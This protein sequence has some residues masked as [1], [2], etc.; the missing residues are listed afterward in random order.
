MLKNAVKKF[1]RNLFSDRVRLT[2]RMLRDIYSDDL[3]RT[4]ELY[5]LH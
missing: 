5:Y 1:W 3:P 2:D 4:S